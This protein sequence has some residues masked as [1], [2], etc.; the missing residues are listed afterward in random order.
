MESLEKICESLTRVNH[1]YLSFTCG[2]E[3]DYIVVNITERPIG[4]TEQLQFNLDA[5]LASI[6]WSIFEHLT[7]RSAEYLGEAS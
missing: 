3:Y 6:T 7:L 5:P 4:N 2:I 1:G